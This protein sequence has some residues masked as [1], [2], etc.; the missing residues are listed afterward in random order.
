[1][2]V[3]LYRWS[4]IFR[5][6][7]IFQE[8]TLEESNKSDRSVMAKLLS[9]SVECIN[10]YLDKVP[11]W[12]REVRKNNLFRLGKLYR[13]LA[14]DARGKGDKLA[15]AQYYLLASNSFSSLTGTLD[16]W[17]EDVRDN[18]P[19]RAGSLYRELAIDAVKANNKE[20][21]AIFHLLASKAFGRSRVKLSDWQKDALDNNPT[22]AASLYRELAI[23]ALRRGDEL[24]AAQYFLSGYIC[25]SKF[26]QSP[27]TKW[28]MDAHDQYPAR[29]ATIYHDLSQQA[30]RKLE[31]RRELELK[32][33]AA[34]AR[35]GFISM[36]EKNSD[37]YSD[38]FESLSGGIFKMASPDLIEIEYFKESILNYYNNDIHGFIDIN[39]DYIQVCLAYGY[40]AD[41]ILNE[42]E[43]F[44]LLLY[45][46]L[47]SKFNQLDKNDCVCDSQLDSLFEKIVQFSKHISKNISS[48]K[49]RIDQY[50]ILQKYKDVS[51]SVLSRGYKKLAAYLLLIAYYN[52]SD[53]LEDTDSIQ[54]EPI[55]SFGQISTEEEV[56]NII[57]RPHQFGAKSTFFDTQYLLASLESVLNNSPVNSRIFVA[58]NDVFKIPEII[59][60][61]L[62]VVPFDAIANVNYFDFLSKYVHFSTNHVEFEM[63]SIATY[64]LIQSICERYSINDFLIV[65]GDTLVLRPLDSFIDNFDSSYYL[66]G[67]CATCFGRLSKD[68]IDHYCSIALQSYTEGSEL[69]KRM[70]KLAQKRSSQQGLRG[71]ICDMTFWEWIIN[72]VCGSNAGFQWSSCDEVKDLTICDQFFKKYDQQ[73]MERIG[74]DDAEFLLSDYKVTINRE[75]RIFSGK[76]VFCPQKVDND[77]GEV[78]YVCQF[79]SGE[80]TLI[81]VNTAQ[82]GGIYKYVMVNLWDSLI[83]KNYFKTYY[84]RGKNLECSYEFIFQN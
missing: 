14:I 81:Q 7:L 84:P 1:M 45:E 54:V 52:T 13:E 37:Y 35:V 11:D 6:G 27:L 63:F 36:R 80:D 16:K 10:E 64:F 74:I 30:C 12:Q 71:G 23:D 83:A 26:R 31:H 34:F 51:V 28:Q 8:L 62:V 58:V 5:A 60:S 61:R 32:I 39:L 41:F 68:L 47:K 43:Q 59:D 25:I 24:K 55:T 57:L 19:V 82:F 17:Q 46:R 33:A 77:V 44:Y 65:E 56:L 15:T 66:S 4:L 78:F 38:F 73:Y 2:T 42:I 29:A 72:D 18:N 48:D 3:Q 40:E 53:I 20:K 9:L 79:S 76:R 75:Q 21:A 67:L 49:S 70:K 69:N 22:R 50:N